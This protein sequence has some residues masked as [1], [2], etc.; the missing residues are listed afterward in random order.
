MQEPGFPE[1]PSA[2][3]I[4][5]A[6]LLASG[7]RLIDVREPEEWAANRIPGAELMPMSAIREWW[8]GLPPDEQIVFQCR[9]GA[10]SAMVV[11]ALTEQAG[12]TAALNLTGGI[13]AWARE[14][15]EIDVRPLNTSDDGG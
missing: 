4:E 15:F 9:T 8:P 11:A 10:R 3:A 14:G 7:V 2:N 13:E 5:A 1:V 6:D 12:F